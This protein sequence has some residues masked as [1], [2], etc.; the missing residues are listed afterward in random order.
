MPTMWWREQKQ[1][2]NIIHRSTPAVKTRL[3]LWL[4]VCV[5]YSLSS[6]KASGSH[7]SLNTLLPKKNLFQFWHQGLRLFILLFLL[8][9]N[10]EHS[11]L[12]TRLG[13]QHKSPRWS[14]QPLKHFVM[15][16]HG[17]GSDRSCSSG[18]WIPLQQCFALGSIN[19]RQ[20]PPSHPLLPA[21]DALCV[22]TQLLETGN[23]QAQLSRFHHPWR[24]V[25]LH[26]FWSLNDR[27]W[28][29][30]TFARTSFSIV[31]IRCLFLSY[32]IVKWTF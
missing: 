2:Q 31:T 7:W 24:K 30:Q 16:A 10:S 29:C 25:H 11:L 8:I 21:Q 22:V 32:V 15:E 13:V 5:M 26:L 27:L 28:H 19:Y 3:R 6:E 17:A 9:W 20:A 18:R 4:I 14:S 1:E 23:S 12:W